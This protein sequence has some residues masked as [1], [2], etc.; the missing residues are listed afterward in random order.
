MDAKIK[1]SSTLWKEVV[2]QMKASTG[3]TFAPSSLRKRYEEIENR[4]FYISEQDPAKYSQWPA[5]PRGRRV[6]FD[7]TP[8]LVPVALGSYDMTDH[9]HGHSGGGRNMSVDMANDSLST[10]GSAEDAEYESF[11][12]AN[13]NDRSMTDSKG[14]CASTRGKSR[15]T[16]EKENESP[17]H[18]HPRISY[19][20]ASYNS[21]LESS[22][23]MGKILSTPTPAAGMGKASVGTGIGG[24]VGYGDSD[25]SDDSG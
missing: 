18:T 24:L 17:S 10:D 16:I 5:L 6:K 21:E 23:S 15:S 13:G 14:K 20:K 7:S 19:G 2:V 22:K 3:E 25:D 4:Q 12:T 11:D 1:T 8:E 9:A